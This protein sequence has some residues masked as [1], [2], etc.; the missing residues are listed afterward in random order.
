MSHLILT[1]SL[2][3]ED[4]FIHVQISLPT[5]FDFVYVTVFHKRTKKL[6]TKENIMYIVYLDFKENAQSYVSTKLRE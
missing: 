6:Y 3:V 1:T 5:S 2:A 4:F